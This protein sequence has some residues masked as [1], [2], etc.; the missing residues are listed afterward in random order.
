MILSKKNGAVC[1]LLA[2]VMKSGRMDVSPYRAVCQH[3]PGIIA[4]GTAD[5]GCVLWTTLRDKAAVVENIAVFL[6]F[7]GGSGDG[8][9][10]T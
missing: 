2:P 10:G 1:T 4:P 6:P 5:I 8:I 7:G 3:N 9:S